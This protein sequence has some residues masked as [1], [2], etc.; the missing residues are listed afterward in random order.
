MQCQLQ[1]NY[2]AWRHTS[3]SHLGYDALH[4]AYTMQIVVNGLSEVGFAEECLHYIKTLVDR[5]NVHKREH[6]P[7]F[8]HAS[9]H[10]CRGAV[11]NIEQRNAVVLHRLQKFKR[12]YGELVESDITVLFNSAQRCNVSQVGVLRHFKILQYGS[13][14]NHSEL[15][16]FNAETL[17]RLCSEMLKQLLS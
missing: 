17:K 5:S 3:Y 11:D 14:S 4:V 16:V 12:A 6:S 2:L 9:T 13:G 1:L 7:T 10:R 15:Q 8:Q